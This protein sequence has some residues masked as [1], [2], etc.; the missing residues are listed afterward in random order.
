MA[1]GKDRFKAPRAHVRHTLRLL[2][3][4]LS[5][6]QT[7][8]ETCT[9]NSSLVGGGGVGRPPDPW[10]CKVRMTERHNPLGQYRASC[11]NSVFGVPIFPN[12][13]PTFR[14]L[15]LWPTMMIVWG[16][17]RPILC[18]DGVRK[19]RNCSTFVVAPLSC[20]PRLVQ[21]YDIAT[22]HQ[23]CCDFMI[24]SKRLTVLL[25]VL[26]HW[27]QRVVDC[28]SLWTSN[29][30]KPRHCSTFVVAPVFRLLLLVCSLSN[31]RIVLLSW[32]HRA[33]GR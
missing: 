8:F 15:S 22:T 19:L 7:D 27:H 10:H 2:V 31:T 32:L 23:M 6:S 28:R 17:G 33:V 24:A 18:L 12:S 16:S 13:R 20:W 30:P 29:S 1:S 11:L 3:G 25:L 21:Y 14:P 26:C 9:H 4:L 5:S